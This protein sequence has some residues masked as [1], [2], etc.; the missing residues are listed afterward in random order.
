MN[1]LDY[2]LEKEY[3][4]LKLT[5]EG[6]K[7][8]VIDG[9]TNN[10]VPF[11]ILD[12]TEDVVLICVGEGESCR[13]GF[14]NEQGGWLITPRYNEAKHFSEGLAAVS[15][16]YGRTPKWGYIDKKGELVISAKLQYAG[17]FRGGK[18][19]V[20]MLDE[21]TKIDKQGIFDDYLLNLLESDNYSHCP[22]PRMLSDEYDE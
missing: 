12:K 22:T 6:E 17:D 19:Q 1:Q 9:K 18:A 4:T 11:K 2:I 7:Y 5:K 21:M 3:S 8:Q 13:Y 15:M 14:C 10:P 16:G 20:M